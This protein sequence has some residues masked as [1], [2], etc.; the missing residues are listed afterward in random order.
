MATFYVLDGAPK[1]N[2]LRVA[3]HIDVP[4]GDN[5]AGV[6]WSTALT[7]YL[8]STQSVVPWL[9][10]ASQDALDAGTR[11]ELQVTVEDDAEKSPADRAQTVKDTIQ[12]AVSAETNRLGNVLRFWGHEGTVT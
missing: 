11:Y 5:A 6:P 7:Q 4:S 1:N 12:A 10:Q 2:T 9:D 8:E 3:V